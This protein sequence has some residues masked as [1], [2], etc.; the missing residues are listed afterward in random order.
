MM[1]NRKIQVTLECFIKKDD[2]YLLLHRHKNKKI[3]PGV[4]MA[5]GGRREFNEGLFTAA[6][7]EVEEE[8]GLK[9]KNLRLRAVGN[10]HLKD[11]DEE[12]YFFMVVADYE[13]GELK[14]NAD[15]GDFAWLT[16]EEV[17]SLDNLLA[18]LK[19]VLPHILSDDP[20]V[21][22]YKAVYEKGNDMSFF[23]IEKN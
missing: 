20:K 3:M 18:E 11:L 1:K 4:W 10:A 13:Q 8:T 5:P 22:S 2:R 15:D 6:R 23:E 7:R 16:K 14:G 21:I 17:M 19:H 9:I 12:F